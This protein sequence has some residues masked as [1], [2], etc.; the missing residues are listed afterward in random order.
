MIKNEEGYMDPTYAG[1]YKTI[2][3]EEKRKQDEADAATRLKLFSKKLGLK[4]LNELYLKI[5]ELEGFTDNNRRPSDERI[6]RI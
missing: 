3:Q 5:S 6:Q 1:A 4:S 2:R